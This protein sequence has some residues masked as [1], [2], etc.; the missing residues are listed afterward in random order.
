MC[1]HT[2]VA[3]LRFP[4]AWQLL[5]TNQNTTLFSVALRHYV[6]CMGFLPSIAAALLPGP[7]L[8][9]QEGPNGT[10]LKPYTSVVQQIERS[11]KII[12]PGLT[13]LLLIRLCCA[14]SQQ[15]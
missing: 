11:I 7:S 2:P 3:W 9:I 10:I 15:H 14:S 12:L 13:P 1:F 5:S 4:H 8:L 6:I